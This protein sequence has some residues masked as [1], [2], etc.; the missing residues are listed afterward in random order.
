MPFA[1][2][3]RQRGRLRSEPSTRVLA[4]GRRRKRGS[5][6]ASLGL[7]NWWILLV[8]VKTSRLQMLTRGIFPQA[9]WPRFGAGGTQEGSGKWQPITVTGGR[10]RGAKG[11]SG[12]LG[13]GHSAR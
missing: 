1:A 8:L 2:I 3:R 4:E 11:C 10:L 7:G 13:I 12:G 6:S 5:A 9:G